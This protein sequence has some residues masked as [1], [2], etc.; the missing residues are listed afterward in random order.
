MLPFG[1]RVQ[2]RTAGK[3]KGGVVSSRW[4]DD[5]WVGRRFSSEEQLVADMA[6]G[7]VYRA[8]DVNES[9]EEVTMADLIGVAGRAW[10]PTCASPTR[11]GRS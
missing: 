8:R 5:I 6:D 3:V 2:F 1:C 9:V 10:S 7:R 11:T 4:F